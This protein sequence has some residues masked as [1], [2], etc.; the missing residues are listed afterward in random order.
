M[1]S[2]SKWQ[3]YPSHVA[4]IFPAMPVDHGAEKIAHSPQRGILMQQQSS[5]HN[6]RISGMW[7]TTVL[8][9]T[10]FA[11][12]GCGGGEEKNDPTQVAARVNGQDVTVHQLNF[13][14]QQA[15]L[16]PEDTEEASKVFLN[17][18]IDQE[19]VVQKALDQKLDKTPRVLQALEAARREVLA[20]AYVEQVTANP[21][22]PQENQI[23]QYYQDHPE[24]FSKRQIYLLQEFVLPNVPQEKIEEVR[25]QALS[26]K[27]PSEFAN[28]VKSSD[29]R[30]N[31]SAAQR[32]AEQIPM[33]LLTKLAALGDGSAL[34]VQDKGP[35]MRILFRSAS[36]PDPVDFERARPAVEQFLVN[37]ARRDTLNNDLRLLRESAKVEYQGKFSGMKFQ[38]ESASSPASG[39]T[40]QPTTEA[41]S[42]V[43]LSNPT[44]GGTTVSLPG[45]TSPS[46]QVSLPDVASQPQK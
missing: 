44:T 8:L 14:L 29:L 25:R 45:Q 31:S 34:V 18:L 22:R 13:R 20:R 32:P 37:M 1:I 7:A 16:R 38:V 39:V 33:D 17:Q 36:R 12:A 28:W 27:S 26:A 42:Q 46:I 15:R 41:A 19:L 10:T 11:L 4:T 23:K 2:E 9:A 24:L 30:A 40:L 3:K 5:R 6:G 35:A 43:Q 21:L